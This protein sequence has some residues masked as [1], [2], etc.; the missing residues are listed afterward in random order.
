[1]AKKD[2]KKLCPN[3]HYYREETIDRLITEAVGSLYVNDVLAARLREHLR[4]AHDRSEAPRLRELR[5]LQAAETRLTHKLG[6]LYDYRLNEDITVDEYRAKRSRIAE[7]LASVRQ[8]IAD[9]GETNAA[10]EE[11]G[12]TI[13]ELL[14]GFRET[15]V[16]ADTEGKARILNVVLDHV[17]LKGKDGAASRFVFRPPFNLLFEVGEHVRKAS[18]SKVGEWGE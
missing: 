8:R 15:Y 9:L 11:E 16:R 7:E 17:E 2:G 3:S 1:M 12:S 5:R 18:G 14:K 10:A 4:T 13:L 6:L